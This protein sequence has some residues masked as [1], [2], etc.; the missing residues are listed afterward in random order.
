[1]PI[2]PQPVKKLLYYQLSAEE[3][4]RLSPGRQHRID[5]ALQLAQGNPH[6]AVELLNHGHTSGSMTLPALRR[7]VRT[8]PTLEQWRPTVESFDAMNGRSM[9]V[10]LETEEALRQ[11]SGDLES[12]AELLGIQKQSLQ[13]RLRARPALKHLVA[14][15]ARPKTEKEI[16]E[17]LVKAHARVKLAA[18]RLGMTP[19]AVSQRIYNSP[20]L[21]AIVDAARQGEGEDG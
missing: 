12:A 14:E 8:E 15:T 7:A 5:Y 19:A 20:L 9:Q 3:R 18:K 2:T 17:A 1:M 13:W 6:E 21:R 10:T 16:G 4:D 11:T